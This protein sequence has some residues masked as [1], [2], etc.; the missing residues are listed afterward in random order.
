CR[1]RVVSM[2]IQLIT[3]ARCPTNASDTFNGLQFRGVDRPFWHSRTASANGVT[4]WRS[5]VTLE[6]MLPVRSPHR[7]ERRRARLQRIYSGKIQT[8]QLLREYPPAATAMHFKVDD[9]RIREI[10]IGRA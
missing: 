6:A 9:V 8:F 10:K 2:R 1:H 4:F 5:A 3:Q 7:T